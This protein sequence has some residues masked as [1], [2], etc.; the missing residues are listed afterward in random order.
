MRGQGRRE[1]RCDRGVLRR[2]SEKEERGE[3][4]GR[5]ERGGGRERK[6]CVTED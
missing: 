4:E 1:E 3:R 5:E 6:V 2:G